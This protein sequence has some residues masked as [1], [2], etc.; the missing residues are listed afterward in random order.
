MNFEFLFGSLCDKCLENELENHSFPFD[1]T[2]FSVDGILRIMR[3]LGGPFYKRGKAKREKKIPFGAAID[4]AV[5]MVISKTM[6]YFYPCLFCFV[7]IKKWFM[8][9]LRNVD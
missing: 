9:N 5:L 1:H 3:I 7:G 6:F 8:L 2:Q 4:L